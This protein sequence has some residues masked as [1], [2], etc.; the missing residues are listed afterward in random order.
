MCDRIQNKYP[1]TSTRKAETYG[2]EKGQKLLFMFTFRETI[3]AENSFMI[4]Q[5]VGFRFDS[6]LDLWVS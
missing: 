5:A 4:V 2:A 3:N 6:G 1:E